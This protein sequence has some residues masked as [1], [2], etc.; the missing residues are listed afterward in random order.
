MTGSMT[1]DSQRVYVVES[2]ITE[3]QRRVR[4]TEEGASFG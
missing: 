3:V 4:V 1:S 2:D